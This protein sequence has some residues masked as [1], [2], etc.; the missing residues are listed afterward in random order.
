VNKLIQSCINVVVAIIFGVGLFGVAESWAEQKKQI[1][2][3]TAV[4]NSTYTKQFM[5]DVDTHRQ[6]RI[7]EL[8]RIFPE[9]APEF[10]GVK[11]AEEWVRGSSDYTDMNGH[12][13]AQGEYLMSNGDKIFSRTDG[14]SQT[15][16]NSDGTKKSG[17][18]CTKLLHGGTGKFVNIQGA[19]RCTITFDIQKGLNEEQVEGEYW[20]MDSK[21]FM[22]YTADVSSKQQA[23]DNVTKA[24]TYIKEAGKEKSFAEINN[25][26]GKFTHDEIYIFAYDLSGR[27]L[28][29]GQYSTWIDKTPAEIN[30]KYHTDA[31]SKILEIGKGPG[32]GWI[33]YDYMNPITGKIERKQS[34]IERSGD[35]IVGCGIYLK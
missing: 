20:H 26:K 29:H 9:Q 19:L 11:I 18:T 10:D 14:I 4:E 5:I 35:V 1:T 30:N 24:I 3:K 17:A 27:V 2:Y 28:A 6:L 16:N 21:P 32:K 25:S 13:W 31:V 8:H 12:W 34:Y 7:Y 22:G 23:Q 15:T 33:E